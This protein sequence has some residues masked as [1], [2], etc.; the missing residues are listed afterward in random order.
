MGVNRLQPFLERIGD[1]GFYN[2]RGILKG[3]ML[4]YNRQVEM[5]H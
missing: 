2:R 3:G 1:N 4:L 5:D